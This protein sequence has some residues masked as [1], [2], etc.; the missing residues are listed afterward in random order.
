MKYKQLTALLAAG[1][2]TVSPAGQLL[3]SEDDLQTAGSAEV[4]ETVQDE[5]PE[6][7]VEEAGEDFLDGQEADEAVDA[8]LAIPISRQRISRRAVQRIQ[9]CSWKMWR[10]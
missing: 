6:V 7:P 10:V 8:G 1:L 9:A 4:N 5:Q 2:L 3:A